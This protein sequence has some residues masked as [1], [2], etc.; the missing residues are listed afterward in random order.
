MNNIKYT[1]VTR[2]SYAD[3]SH[4]KP[5]LDAM[6]VLLQAPM[7]STDNDGF[8]EIFRRQSTA[9][10][11]TDVKTIMYNYNVVDCTNVIEYDK[12]EIEKM[13]KSLDGLFDM[14]CKTPS[15]YKVVILPG[16]DYPVIHL[17]VFVN[18]IRACDKRKAHILR[19]RTHLLKFCAD[20]TTFAVYKKTCRDHHELSIFDYGLDQLT[21]HQMFHDVVDR[22]N[23]YSRISFM[24]ADAP[25]YSYSDNDSD[26]SDRDEDS[27]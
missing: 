17:D 25:I 6:K 15:N 13:D 21:S 5:V 20:E 8:L 24:C 3:G 2:Q 16:D 18:E 27:D 22:S 1:I 19:A 26:D 12:D 10:G 4:P 7:P 9:I 23:V 11:K 14:L